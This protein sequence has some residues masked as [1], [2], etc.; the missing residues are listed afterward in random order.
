MGAEIKA[1]IIE[2]EGNKLKL[3][4]VAAVRTEERADL[5]AWKKTQKPEGGGKSGLG[6]LADKFKGLKLS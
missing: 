1:E 2:V 5:E 3:S 6:T 4:I